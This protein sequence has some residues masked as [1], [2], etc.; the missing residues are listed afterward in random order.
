[1][2]VWSGMDVGCCLLRED[3]RG[4]RPGCVGWEGVNVRWWRLGEGLALWRVMLWVHGERVRILLQALEVEQPGEK[5][6]SICFGLCTNL[7]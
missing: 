2:G 7:Q 4:V 3:N 1:M 6:T 5:E